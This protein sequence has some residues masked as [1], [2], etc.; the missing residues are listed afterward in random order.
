M[1]P[2][3]LPESINAF[4]SQ[5]F[6]WAKGSI[7]TALKLL[8]RVA[9][10]N[11]SAFAKWQA[12]LHMTHYAIHPIMVWLSLL[13]LPLL[14]FTE[15]RYAPGLAAVLFGLILFSAMAPLVLYSASQVFLYPR[16]YRRLR[17][18][19]LLSVLGVGIAISNTRAVFEAVAGKPSAF[20]R[21]PKKGDRGLKAYR[22]ALPHA[23]LL[24]LAL[25]TY[26]F[27]SLWYYFHFKT[28][29]VGP[30]LFLYA[31]GFTSV[32]LLSITHALMDARQG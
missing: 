18:L 7:Q 25:G 3:E 10:S 22:M 14:A 29:V 8:P 12:L 5:Q 24:E 16:K 2:A 15:I 28:Y 1:V 13:A 32:G 9:R 11:R 27:V 20:I 26:C 30:F 17:Y 31:I 19:P 21:T 4:K 23:A 6:R